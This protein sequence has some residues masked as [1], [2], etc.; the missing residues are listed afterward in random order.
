MVHSSH[1]HTKN[2]NKAYK[3]NC[4]PEFPILPALK[5]GIFMW[6]NSFYR[7]EHVY[8][9]RMQEFKNIL[10]KKLSNYFGQLLL[11]LF[12]KIMLNAELKMMFLLLMDLGNLGFFN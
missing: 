3:K 7:Y 1:A 6:T 2:L 10:E 8:T 5:L 4:V 9:H 11:N 12:T